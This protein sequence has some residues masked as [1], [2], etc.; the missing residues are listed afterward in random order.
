VS[1]EIRKKAGTTF[2]VLAILF[3]SAYW[4]GM[5]ALASIEATSAA[6]RL[7]AW[8]PDDKKDPGPERLP[9]FK[10][11][12]NPQAVLV[13]SGQQ[14]GYLEPCGCSPEFQKGGLARR[15]GFIKSLEKRNWPVLSADLGGILDDYMQQSQGKF[16][17]GPEQL[18]AKLETALEAMHK[19][20]YAALNVGPEDL[21]THQ[22][23]VGLMG[24][25][26]NLD[27]PPLPRAINANLGAEKDFRDLGLIAPYQIREIGGVKV[28]LIGMAG[29]KNKD[30]MNDPSLKEWQAPEIA[31]AATL[32]ELKRKADLLVLM[33]YGDLDEARQLAAKFNDLDVIIH[34]SDSEEPSDMAEIHEKNKT[35]LVTI[36]SKGKYTGTIGIF[37]SR[38]RLRFELVPLDDRFEEDKDLRELLDNKYIERLASLNLVET[39]PKVVC[40]KD[41]PDL[42]FVGSAKCGECHT[43]VYKFWLTTRHS[44]AL[45]TLVNGFVDPKHGKKIA[46]G[47]QVNPECVSCHTTGFF[48]VSGYDGTAKTKHLGGN[49]CENCHGPG[50]EH[51]RIMSMHDPSKVDQQRAKKMMHLELQ[52]KERNVCIKCHDI[53]NSPKFK[54]DKY[55]EEVDHG[56]EAIEDKDNWP[57]IREKLLNEKK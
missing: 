6:P 35:M 20:R 55:W 26:L 1:L 43:S 5:Q 11:W 39:A 7:E 57:K 3:G 36:G 52:T 28:A 51:A 53:E 37:K 33:L 22:G 21:N 23:F 8:S 56:A 42:G 9:I 15:F 34:A 32:K 29:T 17:A 46:P 50:S 4:L 30:R 41:N 27:N 25:L 47:K 44:H 12:P 14:R 49:G 48:N 31:L 13:F 18:Q 19:M 2:V 16:M 24:L 40:S 45:D 54:I 10:D 38:P